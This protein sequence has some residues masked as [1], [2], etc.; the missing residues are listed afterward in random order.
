MATEKQINL[1]A[2]LSRLP[3][4]KMV[5]IYHKRKI[6]GHGEFFRW[7][8]DSMGEKADNQIYCNFHSPECCLMGTKVENFLY[9][10]AFPEIPQ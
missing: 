2:D 5:L 7:T 6:W 9:W 8:E 1:V 4:D 3:L 10:M